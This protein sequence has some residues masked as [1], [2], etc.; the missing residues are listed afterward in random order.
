MFS[1][2]SPRQVF[3][4]TAT[5]KRTAPSGQTGRKHLVLHQANSSTTISKSADERDVTANSELHKRPASPDD[6]REGSGILITSL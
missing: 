5:K 6:E 1:H 2:M 3:V 4:E